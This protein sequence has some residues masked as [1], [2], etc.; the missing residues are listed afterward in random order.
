MCAP[1]YRRYIDGVGG[2]ERE[3]IAFLPVP[4]SFETFAEVERGAAHLGVGVRAGCVGVGVDYCF[5][6]MVSIVFAC[7]GRER[8][9]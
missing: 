1:D 5:G 9:N 6:T 2:V 3:D 4:E 8:R 7:G